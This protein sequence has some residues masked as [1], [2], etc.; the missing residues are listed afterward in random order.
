MVDWI[1]AGRRGEVPVTPAEGYRWKDT[2]RLNA[3]VVREAKKLSYRTVRSR[4]RQAFERVQQTI[5]GLSDED[6][7]EMGRFEWA[8]KYPLARW[9]SMNTVRQYTTARTYVRRALRD[10]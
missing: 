5:D 10:R 2:P 6:L 3:Q 4:L 9:I 1:E 7:E 8:G